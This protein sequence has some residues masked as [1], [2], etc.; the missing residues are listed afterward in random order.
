MTQ[1]PD[2][3]DLLYHIEHQVWARPH[4]DGWFEIGITALGV[5]LSGEIYMC[6][7]KGVG[8]RVEQGRSIAVAELGKSIVSVKSPL[9]GEVLEVN[10]R[11]KDEPGLVHRFPYGEGWLA[12]I[13]PTALEQEQAALL[14]GAEVAAAM[15]EHARLYRIEY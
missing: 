7:P 4:P 6:R 10:H 11:L 5:H 2:P 9:S 13:R 8:V 15:R 3:P 12:R 1:T 14:T